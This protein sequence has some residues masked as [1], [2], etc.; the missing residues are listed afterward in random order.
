MALFLA[1]S[2][3]LSGNVFWTLRNTGV[4]LAD[5]YICGLSEHTH[6]DECYE[7]QLICGETDPEHIHDEN[8][9]NRVL[10]CGHDE[11]THT[12]ACRPEDAASRELQSE[13]ESKLPQPVDKKAQ[14]LVNTAASQLDYKEDPDGYTRYGAWYGNPTGDWNVMFVSFCLHYSGISE[15]DIPYGSGGWAWQVKLDKCGL[16]N[17]DF[18]VLPQMGDLLL[19]DNDGDGKCDLTGI[20]VDINDKEISVMEGDI[21]GA[22]AVKP[23]NI[24]DTAL[25]AYVSVNKLDQVENGSED[26]GENTESSE[27]TENT[28]VVQDGEDAPE[29]PVKT[30]LEFESVTG[31]GITVNATAPYGAFPEGTTM[32][33][34]DIANSKVKELA[35]QTVGE[36]KEIKGMVAVDISFFDAEGNIVEP[37]EGKTVDVS[38]KIPE[39]RQPEGQAFDLLHIEGR[40]VSVVEGAEVSSSKAAFTADG[41]SIYVVTATGEKDKDKVHAYLDNAG[42]IVNPDTDLAGDTIKNTQNFPYVLMEGDTLELIGRIDPA[43]A[44]GE[45]LHIR[46]FDNMNWMG[47]VVSIN[48]TSSTPT[49]VRATITGISSQP[50]DGSCA[51]SLYRG[52]SALSNAENFSIRVIRRN[53]ETDVIDFDQHNDGDTVNVNYGDTIVI[54]GTPN[55]YGEDYDWPYIEGGQDRGILSAFENGSEDAS[56]VRS[57]TCRAVNFNSENNTQ[58]VSFWTENGVMKRINVVVNYDYHN[59]NTDYYEILDHADIE[60]AD[61]GVYTSVSF[62]LGDDNG[63]IKTVTEYQSYVSGVNSCRIYDEKGNL[64]PFFETQSDQNYQVTNATPLPDNGFDSD[65][66]WSDPRFSP[67]HSQYELTSKYHDNFI[68]NNRHFRYKDTDHVV[69][70]VSLQIAPTKIEKYKYNSATGEWEIMAQETVVYTPD[71][72]NRKYTKTVNGI[73]TVTDGDLDDIVEKV[74]SQVF[75]LD[76][77]YVIDAYNKCPNHSGLDFTVHANTASVQFGAT[78]ELTNGVLRGGDFTFELVDKN[79]D[80]VVTEV[81][82]AEGKVLF[83]RLQFDHPGTYRFC[84]RE[85]DDHQAGIRYDNSVYD[86]TVEVTEIPNTGGMLMADVRE[87]NNNY[88]FKFTN[89]VVFSLPNTGGPGIAPFIAAGTLMIGGALILLIKRRCEGGGYA[90]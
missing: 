9:Y 8:C 6:S 90:K 55:R 10:T 89:S 80:R 75:E 1:V 20:I 52:N 25:Y 7:E 81:N 34:S 65:D 70:D 12:D 40:N 64:T 23:Y 22:V 43:D 85:K 69:F 68:M 35:E 48:E 59:E 13:W 21:D 51:V 31:S 26:A 39:A 42:V 11:H 4:A 18:T 60:I 44:N 41:F 54:K 72:P 56:G 29:D 5:E 82:N 16:L 71:Y 67:G 61:G 45:N 88:T 30:N 47:D 76:K 83:E 46:F 79:T 84:I 77:R 74:D 27:S 86:V 73:V 63:M 24:P 14:S 36:G 3:V 62:E 33:V 87:F 17:R 37:E 53:N 57:I 66:Y 28:D 78:K 38:I 49:E 2:I 58:Q 32:N 50:N 15:N 19:I